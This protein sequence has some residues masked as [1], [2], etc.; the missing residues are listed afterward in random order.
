MAWF[1]FLPQIEMDFSQMLVI[2]SWSENSNRFCLCGLVFS[3]DK[4]NKPNNCLKDKKLALNSG[5]ATNQILR[6]DDE[7][8]IPCLS[9]ISLAFGIFNYKRYALF[10][11]I[12]WMIT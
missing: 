8:C 11:D 6:N 7:V 9:S 1:K 5:I 3:R 4:K 12:S 2:R 10:I